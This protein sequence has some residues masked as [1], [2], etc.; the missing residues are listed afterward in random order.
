VLRACFQTRSRSVNESSALVGPQRHLLPSLLAC[1][2]NSCSIPLHE[3]QDPDRIWTQYTRLWELQE[4]SRRPLP[5]L[6]ESQTYGSLVLRPQEASTTSNCGSSPPDQPGAVSGPPRLSD[7]PYDHLPELSGKR[8]RDSRS[9]GLGCL[10][11]S[12]TSR[13]RDR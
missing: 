2:A 13:R 8:V 11:R 12:T 10:R 1:G 9:R 7:C 6:R 3:A 5:H 4:S